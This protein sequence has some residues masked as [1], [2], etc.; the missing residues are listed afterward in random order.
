VEE[1]ETNNIENRFIK[2]GGRN[3]L[4]IVGEWE[5]EEAKPVQHQRQQSI[6][7]KERE[8]SLWVKQ[9]II[10]PDKVL[11]AD[12]QGHEK[13]ALELLL[14]VDSSRQARRMENVNFCKNTR[15]RGSQELKC[16]VSFDVKF[17]IMGIG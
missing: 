3:S 16:L 17:N 4:A 10:K 13:E 1:K 2:V 9:N 7:C 14:P 12:F 15:F 8:T 6:I 5:I 11:G